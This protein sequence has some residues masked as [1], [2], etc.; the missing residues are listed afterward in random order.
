MLATIKIR[1]TQGKGNL[2]V[3]FMPVNGNNVSKSTTKTGTIT[4]DSVEP[5]DILSIEGA[6][7]G[8]AQIDIDP[9][10]MPETPKYYP[11]GRILDNFIIQ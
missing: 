2:T 6:C 7:A 10:T 5:G 11:A 8:N 3:T 4:F 9:P 1:F